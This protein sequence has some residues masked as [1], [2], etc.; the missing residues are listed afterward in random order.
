MGLDGLPGLASE[1]WRDP[2]RA[3]SG[4]PGRSMGIEQARARTTN[5][6]VARVQNQAPC[7]VVKLR[8]GEGLGAK[9]VTGTPEKP[10]T[11][12]TIRAP[13]GPRPDTE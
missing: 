3:L 5:R 6:D 12:A 9:K 1:P 4:A 8:S 10:I 2:M 13:S 7:G 11:A